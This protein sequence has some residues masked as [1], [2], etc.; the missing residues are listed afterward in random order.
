MSWTIKHLLG[1]IHT[2]HKDRHAHMHHNLAKYTRQT[3]L[4]IENI[5]HRL[6]QSLKK[7]AKTKIHQDLQLAWAPFDS[8]KQLVS[9]NEMFSWKYQ[10][11]PLNFFNNPYC[12]VIYSKRMAWLQEQSPKLLRVPACWASFLCQAQVN[13]PP[14]GVDSWNLPFNSTVYECWFCAEPEDFWLQ[15]CLQLHKVLHLLLYHCS[16]DVLRASFTVYHSP[17]L[18]DQRNRTWLQNESAS[19]EPFIDQKY[20]HWDNLIIVFGLQPQ[21]KRWPLT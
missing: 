21:K 1:S 6:Q 20:T 9:R 3:T 12:S 11:R 19:F 17:C 16:H 4:N 13:M 18:F 15:T 10:L 5:T 7:G 8:A 14:V 2:V